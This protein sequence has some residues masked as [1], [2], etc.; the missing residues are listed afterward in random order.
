ML[1]VRLARHGLAVSAGSLAAVLAQNM[2]S[3]SAPAAVVRSTIRAATLFAA[4]QT[5]VEGAISVKAV[6]LT[7][8]VLKAMFLSKLK[9]AT[10]VVLGVGLLGIGW[11]IYPTRAATPPDE[12]QEAASTSPS[13]LGAP[14]K[15]G[16][17]P[18]KDGQGEK[19]IGLPKGPAPFQVLV[20]LK[21][22]KL[23]V[24]TEQ[25]VVYLTRPSGGQE[26]PPMP[27]GN[28]IYFGGIGI[29]AVR[30]QGGTESSYDLKDV[31]VLDTKGQKVGKK[32]LATLLK[33]ETVAVAS[34]HHPIDP[35]HLRI[36]KEGTL[37][38]I[39]PPPPAGAM[40]GPGEMPLA[41]GD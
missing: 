10:A 27:E 9:I 24:K 25:V 7:E 4:G 17:K 22:G 14:A 35:L 26:V 3:A 30:S 15:T 1:A 36:L 8:G 2:A 33:E 38:F 41:E 20:S 32:E 6:A 39:L 16:G 13:A 12:N 34:F 37:V 23:V 40:P 19:K 31:L 18:A 28:R 21:D 29:K 5:A 11:G